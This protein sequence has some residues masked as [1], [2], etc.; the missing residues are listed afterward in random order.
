MLNDIKTPGEFFEYLCKNVNYGYYTKQG[1]VHLLGEEDYNDGWVD[2]YILSSP[3]DVIKNRAGT[4]W[5][6][7]ELER[8]WF[9]KNGYEVKTFYEMVCVPYEN[10][11]ETHSFLA[12]KDKKNWF[13]FEFS[14]F[15]NR[16]I[17]KFDTLEELLINV[18][19]RYLT[20]LNKYDLNRKEKDS[21]VLNEYS[22]PKEHC[23]VDEFIDNALKKKL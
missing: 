19:N 6:L 5:D 17:Y 10:D 4:C 20:N 14:D 15:V 22:K 9:T 3:E 18:H 12:F 11:F 13:Y 21:I 8:E 23:S 1:K 2:N 7:V 16:G